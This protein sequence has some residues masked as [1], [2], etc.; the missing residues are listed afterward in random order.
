M[1]TIF[2]KR[3]MKHT[4]CATAFCLLILAVFVHFFS[5]SETTVRA[6]D[7]SISIPKAGVLTADPSPIPSSGIRPN[8]LGKALI[9]EYHLIQP[10]PSRWARSADDFRRDLKMLYNAGYRTLSASDYL[11]GKIDLPAGTHPVIFTFDDSSPGQFRYLVK[12]GKKEID[13]DCAVG[14]FIEFKKRHPDFGMKATFFVL[15][16]ADEPH[17][18]F[19]QPEFESDKLKELAALGFEIGNHT[20]WH[21]NLKKYDAA[22]V[23][24]Q[25]GRAV[26][27]IEAAVPGYNVNSL[28]LPFGAY[29][30][31]L[32]WA[33]DGAYQGI[34]YHNDGIFEVT[35][36]PALSPFDSRW[37]PLHLPRIQVVGNDLGRRIRYFEQHPEE[38]FRSDGRA[39]TVSFPAG[40]KAEFDASRFKSLRSVVY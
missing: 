24:K 29:P 1:A 3:T 13:P 20:L 32:A 8:E 25:L 15:P 14:I 37:D 36:G 23:R 17:R 16:G 5:I 26:Q 2:S 7:P 34:T 10:Q 33:V 19:G 21:A 12:N 27:A 40:L 28:A 11:R 35:G 22:V 6:A 4:G 18:L 39:D 31:D 30:K 9:L 38:V